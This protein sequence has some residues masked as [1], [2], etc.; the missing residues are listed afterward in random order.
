LESAVDDGLPPLEAD[1]ALLGRILAN[2][3]NNA[4][5]HTRAGGRIAVAARP[6]G[7]HVLITVQD[8]GEGIPQ[9][10]LPYIFEKFVAGESD[11]PRR[12]S[13]APSLRLTFRRLAECSQGGTY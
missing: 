3:L 13:Y 1:R 8:T 7:D 5:K 9:D 4:F 12:M 6:E 10:L 11:H 2:L